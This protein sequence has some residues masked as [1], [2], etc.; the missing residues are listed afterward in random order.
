MENAGGES[1]GGILINAFATSCDTTFAPLGRSS[2][3]HPRLVAAARPLRLR[4]ADTDRQRAESTIPSAG[5]IGGPV[6]VGASAIGQGRVQATTLEMADVAAAI[7]DGGRR[8]VPTMLAGTRPRFVRVTSRRVAGEVQSMMVAVIA[9]GTGTAAQIPGVTV[10]G[11]TGTAELKDTAGKQN[12]AKD[13]DAWFVGYAPVGRAKVVVSALFPSQG[14]GGDTAAPA[15]RQV[16]ET[17]LG[18]S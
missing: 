7:A 15:V 13:T 16:L 10:A 5:A 4:R 2:E 6:A 8:P 17:A 11:K 1:C 3:R 14:Y 9:Y 18:I 12:E